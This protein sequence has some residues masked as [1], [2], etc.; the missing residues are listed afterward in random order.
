M[1]P[2]LRFWVHPVSACV[3]ETPQGEGSLHGHAEYR[4]ERIH[5]ERLSPG[6]LT[7][8]T[9]SVGRQLYPDGC[10]CCRSYPSDLEL[11]TH[12]LAIRWG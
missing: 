5:I 6:G 7:A 9:D 10:L 1:N 4:G 3:C 11:L 2:L 8:M 12:L